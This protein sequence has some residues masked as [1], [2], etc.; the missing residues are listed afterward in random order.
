MAVDIW[1][2]HKSSSE[3]WS[4]HALQSLEL[5]GVQAVP[6]VLLACVEELYIHHTKSFPQMCGCK[7]CHNR[8]QCYRQGEARP[9]RIGRGIN[10]PM[11]AVRGKKGTA[12][13]SRPEH[14][15]GPSDFPCSKIN[16]TH[17]SKFWIPQKG[18]VICTVMAN[19]N[20]NLLLNHAKSFLILAVHIICKCTCTLIVH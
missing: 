3:C 4:D 8:R 15:E 13:V 20:L 14:Q 9:H 19:T 5:Q 1:L 18:S 2:I 17:R 11:I 16:Q 6:L 10:Q 12:T 7:Q